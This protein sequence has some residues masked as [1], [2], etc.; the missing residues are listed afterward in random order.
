MYTKFSWHSTLNFV[1]K[2]YTKVYRNVVYILYIFCIYFVY[3][4]CI[5][6]VQFLNTKCIHSF[7]VDIKMEVLKWKSCKWSPFPFFSL[8]HAQIL[9]EIVFQ[10]IR[11][12]RTI[13]ISISVR[14]TEKQKSKRWN[15]TT[16]YQFKPKSNPNF[17]SKFPEMEFLNKI[18]ILM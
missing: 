16:F 13:L 14:K 4:S 9:T 15:I 6:L 18:L 8:I 12:T 2:M 1:Y 17:G 5:H 11:R 10:L 3:I 7:H